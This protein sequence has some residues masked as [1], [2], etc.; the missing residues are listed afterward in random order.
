MNIGDRIR[1]LRKTLDLTQREFGERVNL[2]SNS[3]ALIEGGRNTSEQTIFSICREFGV[4]EKWLRF[5][6][7]E[8]FLPKAAG[9]LEALARNRGISHEAYI[10]IERLLS[11]EPEILDGLVRYCLEVAEALNGGA[12]RPDTPEA[13]GVAI[14]E[15]DAAAEAA[16]ADDAD[17]ERQA[18]A[19]AA[20]AREQFLLEK[21]QGSGAS[22]AK[23]SGVG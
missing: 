11:V 17:L 5:G 2:K 8:M 1:K 9:D 22:G 16:P 12:V 10:A 14:V 23:G 6:V 4:N 15:A 3:I 20:M 7:G 21:R 19:Y 18:D 13:A